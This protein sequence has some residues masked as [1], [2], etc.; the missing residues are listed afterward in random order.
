MDINEAFNRYKMY[1]IYE[2]DLSMYVEEDAEG[3]LR[4]FPEGNIWDS[5]YCKWVTMRDIPENI[6]KL[7][8][9]CLTDKSA[10]IL[11]KNNEILL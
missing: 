5:V 7:F 4:A 2:I 10:Q 9:D 1:V 3:T 8:L 6:Q 11:E